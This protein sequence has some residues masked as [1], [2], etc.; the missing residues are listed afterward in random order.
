[1]HFPRYIK[2]EGRD[3]FYMTLRH[4][5]PGAALPPAVQPPLPTEG[6]WRLKGLPQHG[7][8]YALALTE[9]RPDAAHPT[10]RLRVLKIDPRTVSASAGAAGPPSKLVAVIDAGLGAPHPSS[11]ASLWHS[12]GA[13]SIAATPPVADAVRIASGPS[14]AAP[15]AAAALGVNDEDGMLIYAE[16]SSKE[17]P[18]TAV[19]PASAGAPLAAAPEGSAAGR[20]KAVDPA[21]AKLLEQ[22]LA[23]LGC[24]SRI[25]LSQPLSI[26]LGGDTDLTGAPVRPPRGAAV[27]HLRRVEAAGARRIF[28]DTPI[29]PFSTWYPLQQQRIRYFKKPPGQA[30]EAAGGDENK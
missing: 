12:A 25:F 6:E 26:V 16:V 27:V 17:P 15:G 4:V 7:F 18:S 23:K 14:S 30:A 5:L 24:S 21:H 8:P 9:V 1:M 19:L 3:Y 10:T 29:V 22:F 11:E 28:E 20:P 2:R 13:F